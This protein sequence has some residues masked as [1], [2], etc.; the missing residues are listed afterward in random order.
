[1]CFYDVHAA[2]LSDARAS[3]GTTACTVCAAIAILLHI[4]EP[5]R[6]LTFCTETE[7]SDKSLYPTFARTKP[8]DSQVSKS[9]VSLLRMFKWTKVTFIHSNTTDGNHTADDIYS[10]LVD[11]GF[12]VLFRKKYPG[13]YFHKHMVNPFVKIVEETYLETRIYVMLGAPYEFVGL[14]DNLQDRGILDAGEYFVIG[15]CLEPYYPE[16]PE[17]FLEGVFD[18]DVTERSALAFRHFVG[19]IHSPPVQPG[20]KAFQKIVDEYL[21]KQPFNFTNPLRNMST[22][23]RIRP[24]AAYLYD[25]VWLYAKA[26]DQVLRE[27]GSLLDGRRIIAHIQNQTYQS[28]FGY[29]S[30][31]N[32]KGDT[33]GNFSLIVRKATEKGWGMFPVGNFRLTFDSDDI[34]TFQF[35][36][37]ETIHWIA[38]RPPLDEPEC[39]FHHERCIPPTSYTKEVVAGIA[40]SLILIGTIVGYLIYR[41]WRYEQDLASLLWKIDFKDITFRR[42]TQSSFL[43]GQISLMSQ[44]DFDFRQLF[45]HVG[46]YRG[47]IVAIRRVNKKHVELTRSVR[48]ELKTMRELRHDNIN[49][50]IGACIDSPSILIVTAYCAKGSLQL[51]LTF[52]LIL[53]QDILENDD[54]QLDSMFIASLVHDIVRVR[55]CGCLESSLSL[56]WPRPSAVLHLPFASFFFYFFPPEFLNVHLTPCTG[57]FVFKDPVHPAGASLSS[58]TSPKNLIFIVCKPEDP[59]SARGTIRLWEERDGSEGVDEGEYLLHVSRVHRRILELLPQFISRTAMKLA[60][61]EEEGLVVASILEKLAKNYTAVST[62]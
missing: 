62:T 44:N 1:M 54:F 58:L 33:E 43:P 26:A 25:A 10:T 24:E 11:H 14:M 48:K 12:K 61:A 31:I 28:A 51:L 22:F 16:N 52:A 53:S 57:I 32:S 4:S 21:E 19:L 42:A 23:R 45:T 47:T 59:S 8:T 40:G 3:P 37:N 38:G 36:G 60:E 41:N 27:G 56:G 46:T 29:L 13:P 35:Y 55:H 15:V 30:K 50:F 17:T 9:V 7:V 39:G 49:P 2:R 6:G 20:Y 5:S 34:P 18:Y